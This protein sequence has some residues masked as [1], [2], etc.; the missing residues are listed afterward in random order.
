[1]I[2]LG[3]PMRELPLPQSVRVRVILFINWDFRVPI[4]PAFLKTPFAIF[5]LGM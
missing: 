4:Y 3:Y 5:L 1:M 2:P